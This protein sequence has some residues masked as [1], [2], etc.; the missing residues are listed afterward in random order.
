MTR[1]QRLWAFAAYVVTVFVL[2]MVVGALGALGPGELLIVL[3]V[4][5]PVTVPVYRTGLRRVRRR[6]G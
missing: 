6:H 5:L 4:A 2:A 3:V 1:L